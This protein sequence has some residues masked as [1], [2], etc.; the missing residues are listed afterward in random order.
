MINDA[1]VNL[2]VT[3]LED[4]DSDSVPD[5]EEWGIDSNNQDFDGNNDSIADYLQS[6][7][8]SLHT[9]DRQQF[10][11][12]S[13]PQPGRLAMCKVKDP[14]Y[15][16]D[17]PLDVSLPLGLIS[18]N[19]ENIAPGT[20]TD[21]TINLPAEANFNSFYK[22]GA[23]LDTPAAHWYEF[24]YDPTSET[25]AVYDGNTV[26]LYFIDGQRGDSDLSEDGVITDPGGPGILISGNESDPTPSDDRQL[27]QRGE[28]SANGDGGCF[29]SSIFNLSEEPK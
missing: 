9:Y 6:N 14:A 19:I 27:G 12:M 18:F 16:D 8:A 29:I 17:S 3:F 22:H 10:I 13:T 15:L 2:S 21:I 1:D 28:A 11:T 23:T 20:A 25:G 5:R 26:T 4:T 24:M 7:V